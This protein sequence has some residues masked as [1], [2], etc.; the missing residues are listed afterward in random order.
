MHEHV[1][2]A[3]PRLINEA[4]YL[5]EVLH[6]IVVDSVLGRDRQVGVDA[7]T[8]RV[9]RLLEVEATRA[10]A[11]QHVRDVQ[12]LQPSDVV[13]VLLVADVEVGGQSDGELRWPGQR[14]RLQDLTHLT[15]I[16]VV[17]SL[18]GASHSTATHLALRARPSPHR[19]WK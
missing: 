7:G 19:T 10:G 15:Q 1:C 18:T 9:R 5:Y 6:D 16:L 17:V 3:P 12:S 13:R 11:V 8:A 14:V 4:E 2:T